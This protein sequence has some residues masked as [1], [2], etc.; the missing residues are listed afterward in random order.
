MTS[1]LLI[2][3][4]LALLAVAAVLAY[5]LI[6]PPQD[7]LALR[8]RVGDLSWSVW[9]QVLSLAGLSYSLRWLRWHLLLRSL[10]HHV[11]MGRQVLIYLAG[12]GLAMTP[13]KVGE[14]I[15]SA[16]LAPE[17]VPYGHSLAAFVAERL[18]DLLVV[19]LL[20]TFGMSLLGSDPIW[21]FGAW[22]GL[23]SVFLLTRS[24]LILHAT[25]ML[26]STPLRATAD[27][28]AHALRHLLSGWPL[29]GAMLLAV[30]AWVA[31]AC[32]LML[33]LQASGHA[34]PFLSMLGTYALAL[35]A[36]A[37]SFVPGGLG[38][39]ETAMLWLLERQGVA[40]AD[41]ALAALV[42]RGIPLWSGVLVGLMALAT[43]GA[44]PVRRQAMPF[45]ADPR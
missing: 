34:L 2:R 31:Q 25:R 33:V 14:T 5:L 9:T 20:A 23:L 16:Y 6:Q 37:A 35:L 21:L 36:G 38:V 27:E 8:Q 41:A 19:G 3:R 40:W 42:S 43:L 17:G 28:G 45:P 44:S 7:L 29:V 12:F 30:M 10:G 1:T 22:A 15:R 18:I 26:G 32:G 24:R 4:G 11:P 39:T 13:G